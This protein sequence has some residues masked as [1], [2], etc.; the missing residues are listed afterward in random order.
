MRIG[1][2]RMLKAIQKPLAHA[3]EGDESKKGGKNTASAR[4]RPNRRKMLVLKGQPHQ[5]RWPLQDCHELAAVNSTGSIVSGDT[6]DGQDRESEGDDMSAVGLSRARFC[7]KWFLRATARFDLRDKEYLEH[8]RGLTGLCR[9]RQPR[10]LTLLAAPVAGLP[11]HTGKSSNKQFVRGIDIGEIVFTLSLRILQCLTSSTRFSGKMSVN[12]ERSI[13]ALARGCT[14]SRATSQI[15]AGRRKKK[16]T[17]KHGGDTLPGGGGHDGCPKR[18][19]GPSSLCQ[20]TDNCGKLHAKSH[21]HKAANRLGIASD[22]NN[23]I[24]KLAKVSMVPSFRGELGVN[25][26]RDLPPSYDCQIFLMPPSASLVLPRAKAEAE[27]SKPLFAK[28]Q[29]TTTLLPLASVACVRAAQCTACPNGVDDQTYTYQCT[30][31]DQTI[32]Q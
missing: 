5:H 27:S 21:V 18:R 29:L 2:D 15:V 14:D 23:Q 3:F 32:C 16:E 26:L 20:P 17:Q 7:G 31:Q 25:T 4:T 6:I 24:W 13:L 12:G 10:E 9:H 28:M 19:Y 30:W 11:E 22:P 8:W 1:V